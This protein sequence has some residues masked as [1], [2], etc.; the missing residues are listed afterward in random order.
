M[1]LRL[2]LCI[3]NTFYSQPIRFSQNND[4]VFTINLLI[5]IKHSTLKVQMKCFFF[6]C[7]IFRRAAKIRKI[8]VYRFL[9]MSDLFLFQSSNG[10]QKSQNHSKKCSRKLSKSVKIH[11]ICDVMCWTRW[12][13]EKLNSQIFINYSSEPSETFQRGHGSQFTT[14]DVKNLIFWTAYSIPGFLNCKHKPFIST[15]CSSR[16]KSTFDVSW[17]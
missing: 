7:W 3:Q 5:N 14:V 12:F 2:C 10:L 8:A 17:S 15:I 11:K 4:S 6:Y 9:I 13:D 1:K 16:C